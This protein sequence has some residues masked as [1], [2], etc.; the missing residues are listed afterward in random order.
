M[1]QITQAQF[2]ADQTAL[3]LDRCTAC[4]RCVEVCPMWPHS[5]ARD[6]P[7]P[8]V[9]RGIVSLLRSGEPT[10]AARAF[11]DTCSGCALC[12][13]VCQEGLDQF[14]LLLTAKVRQNML[15]G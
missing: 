7:A 11:V 9:A 12:R 1:V 4:G 15:D 5:N 3:V 13:D 2:L 6:T 14:N 10:A 8:E